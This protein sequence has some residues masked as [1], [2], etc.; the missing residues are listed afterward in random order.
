MRKMRKKTAIVFA[1]IFGLQFIASCCPDPGT[2]EV[3]YSDINVRT[4]VEDDNTFT[5]T[6]FNTKINKTDFLLSIVLQE[7]LK[8][9]ATL[10]NTINRFGFQKSYATS[11]PDSDFSYIEEVQEITVNQIDASNNTTNVTNNFEFKFSDSENISIA[12]FINRRENWQNG[13]EF[14]LKNSNGID[15]IAKFEV[16]ILLSSNKTLSFTTEQVQ[17]N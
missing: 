8:Q 13:F 14:Y 12:E 15:S 4:L 1:V 10:L 7:D 3:T 17:F 6:N 5:D 2:F 16:T 11:C 9:V